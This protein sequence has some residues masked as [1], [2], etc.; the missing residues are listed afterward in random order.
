MIF[1]CDFFVISKRVYEE[2]ISDL[3]LDE[4]LDSNTNTDTLPSLR[5]EFLMSEC[6]TDANCV[7]DANSV[8]VEEPL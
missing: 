6:L 5:R 3:P 7:F 1:V 8:T 2:K 4:N